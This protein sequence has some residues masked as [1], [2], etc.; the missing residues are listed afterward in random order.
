MDT[1]IVAGTE[2]GMRAILV[3]SGVTPRAGIDT[4]AFRLHYVFDTVGDI[5]VAELN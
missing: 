1:D 4:Y 5:P 3:L 2:A